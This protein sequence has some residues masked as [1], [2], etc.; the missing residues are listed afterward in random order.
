[1]F[2]AAAAFWPAAY[3]HRLYGPGERERGSLEPLLCQSVPPVELAAGM[4][5]LRTSSDI[6]YDRY[7][8]SSLPQS[9]VGCDEDLGFR[10]FSFPTRCSAAATLPLALIGSLFR[11]IWRAFANLSRKRKAIMGIPDLFFICMPAWLRF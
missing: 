4:A 8:F 1:M 11:C 3:R 2:L 5:R 9:C 7:R 10:S 6:R